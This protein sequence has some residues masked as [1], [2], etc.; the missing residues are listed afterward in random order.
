MRR[1]VRLAELDA[2]SSRRSA[3]VRM[4]ARTSRSRVY[5]T[6]RR[7]RASSPTAAPT[8]GSCESARRRRRRFALND[9]GG[10]AGPTLVVSAKE[11]ARPATRSRRGEGRGIAAGDTTILRGRRAGR[12]GQNTTMRRA[13]TT[14][15]SSSATTWSASPTT[16]TTRRR[17]SRSV[18]G[19]TITLTTALQNAYGANTPLRLTTSRR[20]RRVP[21]AAT[22]VPGST[23]SSRAA[24]SSSTEAERRGRRRGPGRAADRKRRARLAAA[25]PYPIDAADPPVDVAPGVHARHRRHETYDELSMDPRH[26]ATSARSSTRTPS[27]SRPPTRRTR[28]RRPTNLPAGQSAAA[29]ARRA[30]PPTS[31]ARLSDAD[32]FTRGI[33]A[34]RRSTR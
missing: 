6:D 2:V 18:S 20:A 4:R 25:N 14:R 28:A 8:A 34:L 17:P 24:T 26:T 32:E 1:P 15:R 3:S 33:D 21:W 31:R 12:R 27:R 23:V 5:T 13:L 22:G 10:G 16:P 11:K 7:Q 29:D 9:R 19:D 30:G